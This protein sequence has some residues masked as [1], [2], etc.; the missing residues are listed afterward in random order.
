MTDIPTADVAAMD[1]LFRRADFAA[2]YTA[3]E[4][5]LWMTIQARLTAERELPEDEL[6]Q[7]AAAGVPEP[8]RNIWQ[9]TERGRP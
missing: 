8:I 7:F 1:A 9:Q 4:E 6:S 5:R 3:L 2:E